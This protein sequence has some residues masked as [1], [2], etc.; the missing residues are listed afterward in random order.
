MNCSYQGLGG[1]FL[2]SER[3]KA[4]AA[5][6]IEVLGVPLHTMGSGFCA[7]LPSSDRFFSDR[8]ATTTFAIFSCEERG[9]GNIARLNHR[10]REL[11]EVLARLDERGI[12]YEGPDDD[13]GRFAWCEDPDGNRV[14]IWEAPR[15][16]PLAG[17]IEVVPSDKRLAATAENL[18]PK[19]IVRSIEV[20]A[21]REELFAAF[22]NEE[23]LRAWLCPDCRV[24]LRI[25]G[26][27]EIYFMPDAPE[28]LR[29]ADGCRVLSFL[30][31]RL[32]CFTWNAPP[33]HEETRPQHTWVVIELAVIGPSETKVTLTHTGWPELS[34]TW[35]ATFDY[36]DDAWE[37]VLTSLAK[38]YA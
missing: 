32:L 16:D 23:K 19:N 13:Y 11:D 7:E 2:Y 17:P 28:G 6:Y 29:G 31:P 10:V 35:R 24:E 1:A 12:A 8:T 25:G 22:T 18:S 27:Y 20:A 26:R 14:E 34:K 37:R 21:T 33:P 5:F 30:P 3:P 36:F 38:H 4:L 9:S 15:R